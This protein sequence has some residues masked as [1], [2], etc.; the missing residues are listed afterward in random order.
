MRVANIIK[1][2]AWIALLA[3][4]SVAGI[5]YVAVVESDIDEGSGASEKIS[6][7]DVRLVT[8][9]LRREA[10]KNLPTGRY[11][12]MTSETV[13]SMG[14][15]VLEECAEENCVI[16][17]GSKIGADYIV[18]GTVSKLESRFTL[19]VE[20]YE[21]D[22]GTLVASCEPVRAESIGELIEKAATVCGN[23]YRTWVASQKSQAS[24]SAMI[25]FVRS[26]SIGGGAF[27]TSDL[28]GGLSWGNGEKIAMPY[29]G[30]GAYLFI[31]ALYAEIFAGYSTGGGYWKSADARI[32]PD[33]LPDMKR[34][35]IGVG[36]FAKYPVE[37]GSVKIFPL[38]GINYEASI[39]GERV[40]DNG[41][42]FETKESTSALWFKAGAGVDFGLSENVYLRGEVLYGVRTASEFENVWKE[43]ETEH[44]ELMVN[45]KLGHGG[46]VK[47]G[48]GVRF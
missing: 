16:A 20:M 12:I 36:I 21:T 23:M 26:S 24:E 33:R 22:N 28:G 11:S 44:T 10:V 45:A 17:L 38:L 31:D 30:G 19:Q 37:T 9:E 32:R 5:K 39:S 2:A 8:A 4:M 25:R 34:S 27:L 43:E 6:R 18:R 46:S 29:Y 41:D 48:A 42:N 1:T 7:A 13:M 40:Y 15:A 35:Y 14:G 47:I 3:G